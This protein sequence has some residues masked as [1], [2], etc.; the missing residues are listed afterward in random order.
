MKRNILAICDSE[1]TYAYRLMDALSRMADFPFELL[2]FTSDEKLQESLRDNAVQ[3]LLIAQADFRDEMKAWAPHIILLWEDPAAARADLPGISKYTSVIRIMKKITE[4]A[5]EAGAVLPLS[6]TDHP[7][8]FLGF[9]T[10]VGRS[11][12][13]T[14]AFVTGQLLARSY[15]VLYL[16]FERFS[17]LESVLSRSFSSDFSDL[18]YYLP[19]AE[20]DFLRHLYQ[21]AEPV[22]GMEA[23]PP[24]LSGADIL[25]TDAEEW[26]RLLEFLQGSRYDYVILDL[27]DCIQGLFTF[28][29]SCSRVYTIVKEDHFAAAKLFQYEEELRRRGYED[30]LQ[31]TKKCRLP[32]FTRLPGDF[33]HLMGSEL[34]RFAERMLAEDGQSGV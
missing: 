24:A 16:N 25:K 1:Q 30:V 33:N 3:V 13:T 22:N 2:T 34:A 4:T 27:S 32:V 12:Q 29:R 10:P 19:E 20:E 21:A 23:V 9:Y 8:H 14:L 15:K 31:K 17:G 11:L 18:L 7:V 28:L 5:A 6:R 26:R